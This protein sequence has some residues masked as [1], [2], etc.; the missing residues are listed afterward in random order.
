M[1][2]LS[3]WHTIQF[4]SRELYWHE[5]TYVYIAKAI[6][7]YNKDSWKWGKYGEHMGI[8]GTYQW[9]TY[10]Q[11]GSTEMGEVCTFGGAHNWV[12]KSWHI[13]LL[14]A[15]CTYIII[16]DMTLLQ[17]KIDSIKPWAGTRWLVFLMVVV[18][19]RLTFFC[20]NSSHNLLLWSHIV[21]FPPV[22]MGVFCHWS[23]LQ[24]HFGCV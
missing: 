15:C 8:K 19:H 2:C 21:V 24:T 3:T 7:K 22:D 5:K 10:V 6:T 17:Q 4:N 12:N 1:L 13:L 23:C 16:Q 9:G 18:F 20:R 14:Y 11:S